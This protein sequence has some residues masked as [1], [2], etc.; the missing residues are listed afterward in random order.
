MLR[1]LIPGVLKYSAL[2]KVE[3]LPTGRDRGEDLIGE[4]DGG[5]P[6]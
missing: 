5:C 4:G 6:Q 1:P 2:A 3:H